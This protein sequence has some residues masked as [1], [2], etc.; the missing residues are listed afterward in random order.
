MCAT[1]VTKMFMFYELYPLSQ[2]CQNP[3]HAKHVDNFFRKYPGAKGNVPDAVIMV[4]PK[5]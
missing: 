5:Y 1:F 4:D 3:D 2:R